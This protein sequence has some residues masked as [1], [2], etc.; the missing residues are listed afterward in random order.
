MPDSVTS[1]ECCECA[2]TKTNKETDRPDADG[3]PATACRP[4]PGA[5]VQTEKCFET[6]GFS[7]CGAHASIVGA[8]NISERVVPAGFAPTKRVEL[9]SFSCLLLRVPAKGSYTMQPSTLKPAWR[10]RC[11]H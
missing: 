1:R 10:H 9:V 11:A 4:G 2:W 3:E 6:D 8:R 7:S 5:N